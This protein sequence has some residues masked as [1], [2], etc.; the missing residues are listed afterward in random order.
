M[1]DL[2]VDMVRAT[3][4]GGVGILMFLENVFPP[5][6]SELVMPLA[7]WLSAQ[8][9][10]A[11][12]PAVGLGSVGS[13]LGAAFWYEVGRRLGKERMKRWAGRHGSW[14]AM[15]PE[16]LERAQGWFA[17]HGGASVFI[18]R[19]VPFLRTAIS[20]PAGITGMALAP[21]LAYS[22]AGTFLWTAALA[23]AGR[24]LGEQF[25]RVGDVLGWVT[26]A[27]VLGVGVWYVYRVVKVHRRGREG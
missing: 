21:F 18:C 15:D 20:V 27:V 25:P 8:G 9:S 6:P 4:A 26:W 1:K 17:R 12:W 7:G 19:L 13:L 14:V 11:F 10:M 24:F 3:G 23:W 5:I 16:D 22:A 2:I